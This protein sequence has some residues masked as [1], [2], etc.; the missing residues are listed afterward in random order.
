M[1]S[2]KRST[3]SLNIIIDTICKDDKEV[4]FIKS[5][6][7]ETLSIYQWHYQTASNKPKRDVGASAERAVERTI[8]LLRD[9]GQNTLAEEVENVLVD[10]SILTKSIILSSAKKE[11]KDKILL[12]YKVEKKLREF[13]IAYDKGK[14]SND[15]FE[16]RKQKI[17]Q[18]LKTSS[19][20]G[21]T[22]STYKNNYASLLAE[23]FKEW[24]K[25]Y[26]LDKAPASFDQNF[27]PEFY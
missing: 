12:V 7:E 13:E 27:E 26:P 1:T 19:N 23:A 8:K 11:M 4:D 2:V 17:D 9:I 25:K 5:V 24:C 10:D 15:V 21:I 22:E 14:I 3:Y 16:E 6:L 20:Y 18:F